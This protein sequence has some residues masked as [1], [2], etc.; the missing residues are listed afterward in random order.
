MRKLIPD[1]FQPYKTQRTT[2]NYEI[3]HMIFCF[4]ALNDSLHIINLPPFEFFSGCVEK[5]NGRKSI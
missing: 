2:K 1:K 4:S 5:N 3:L